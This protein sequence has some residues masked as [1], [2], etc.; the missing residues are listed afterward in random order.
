MGAFIGRSGVFLPK[1][2]L[3]DKNG[4]HLETTH[5]TKL[6]SLEKMKKAQLLDYEVQADGMPL[7]N[8][9]DIAEELEKKFQRSKYAKS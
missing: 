4:R 8:P 3:V 9:A 7:T 2:I 1:V 5:R 6:P